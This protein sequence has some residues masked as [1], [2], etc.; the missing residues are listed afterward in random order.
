MSHIT[1]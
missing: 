1:R